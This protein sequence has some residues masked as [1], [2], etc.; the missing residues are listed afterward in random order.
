M[1]VLVGRGPQVNKFEQISSLGHQL[2]LGGGPRT[3]R[4]HVWG[5][6]RV[7]MVP[8][9]VGFPCRVWGG[10][11]PV[12]ALYVEVQCIMGNCHIGT[13]VG[14]Q[15]DTTENIFFPQLHRRAVN[16]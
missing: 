5:G 8:V 9:L 12:G 16:M 4:S 15:T 6:G 2:S 11:G 7:G 10:L 3:V 14:R 1:P 13:P